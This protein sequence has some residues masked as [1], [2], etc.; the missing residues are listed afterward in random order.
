MS[1]YWQIQ[2]FS[3]MHWY[4]LAFP[5][6]FDIGYTVTDGCWVSG[7][8]EWDQGVNRKSKTNV[9]RFLEEFRA[10]FTDIT[11]VSGSFSR[12]C[13]VLPTVITGKQLVNAE[14]VLTLLK[15]VSLMIRAVPLTWMWICVFVNLSALVWVNWWE[16]EPSG[17][18]PFHLGIRA[19]SCTLQAAAL[20]AQG[21]ISPVS[22]LD[23][24]GFQTVGKKMITALLWAAVVHVDLYPLW[25]CGMKSKGRAVNASP[26]YLAFMGIP[27]FLESGQTRR[28]A[29]Q[30]CF[31][32][33]SWWHHKQPQI[34]VSGGIDFKRNCSLSYKLQHLMLIPQEHWTN[35][36]GW[37]VILTHYV[38]VQNAVKRSYF[39]FFL[40]I[41][42]RPGWNW[43]LW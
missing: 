8:H 26:I 34:E 32:S 23:R 13:S 42:A 5:E 18:E 38:S 19:H 28:A 1:S 25:L 41:S 29:A 17:L 21:H 30:Y 24:P 3:G 14:P 15:M 33:P 22:Q 16:P 11:W 12:S 9:Q 40:H 4:S 27:N 37:H 39:L 10:F 31:C 7:N 20:W 2:T 36:W 6:D 35:R 43:L